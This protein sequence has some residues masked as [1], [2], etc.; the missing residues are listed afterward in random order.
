MPLLMVKALV[1]ILAIMENLAPRKKSTSFREHV[2]SI[3]GR[4]LKQKLLLRIGKI[5]MLIYG[6]VQ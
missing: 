2:T 5:L 1:S 3:L 4:V 6:G